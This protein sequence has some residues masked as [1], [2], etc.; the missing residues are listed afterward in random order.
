MSWLTRHARPRAINPTG[1]APR[2]PGVTRAPM[3]LSDPAARMDCR[4]SPATTKDG[5]EARSSAFQIGGQDRHLEIVG[6][7]R[8]LV[9]HEQDADEFL[10]DIDLGGILL[11]GPRHHPDAGVAEQLFEI[12][13]QFADFLDVHAALL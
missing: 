3:R 13:I 1:T 8:V 9:V 11:L 7:L 4:S 5:I 6:A 10:A 2:K 12:H